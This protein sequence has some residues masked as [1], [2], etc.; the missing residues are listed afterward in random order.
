MLTC[1]TT[2]S[3]VCLF[4][5]RVNSECLIQRQTDTQREGGWEEKQGQKQEDNEKEDED[6]EREGGKTLNI[7]EINMAHI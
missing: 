4:V 2:D 6:G 3:E 5:R 7:C 1:V